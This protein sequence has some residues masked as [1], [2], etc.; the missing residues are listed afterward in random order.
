MKKIKI[1]LLSNKKLVE[2]FS[3]LTLLQFLN[4]L[5]PL[6]SYPYLV[7]T[8]GTSIYGKI[9]FAT[10]ILNYFTIFVSFGFSTSATKDV[11]V[12][13]DNKEKLAEIISSV[14]I[15]RL[16]LFIITLFLVGFLLFLFEDANN[17]KLLYL[18]SLWVCLSEVLFPS[19]YFQGIEKMKYISIISFVVRLIST[20]LLF[21]YVTSKD[22]YLMVPLLNLLSVL[23]AGV[24]SFRII[25]VSHKIKLFIPDYTVIKG[26]FV[27]SMPIFL[28]NASIQIYVSTNK[29][30]IGLFLGMTEVSYYDLGEKLLNILKIPQM[31]LGQALF[32][33]VSLEKNT[34]FLKKIFKYSMILNILLFFGLAVFADQIIV[35]IAGK[36]MLLAKW[37]VII[38]GL[39][40]PIIAA[41]N[42]FGILTL[43]PFGFNKVFSKIIMFSGLIFIVQ[44]LF[45]WIFDLITIY[46]LSSITVITE[47][48]VTF[49]MYYYCKKNNLWT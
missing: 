10:A 6:V 19:F 22:D 8:L 47:L 12:N 20:A 39:T 37:V 24:I 43:I 3:Y 34:S 42:I 13:R 45:L 31:I 40:L 2:N 49:L 23:I 11:S 44:F 33:K 35:L 18:A 17:N 29:V 14:L 21:V 4:L 46:S 30:L 48:F 26:Y 27:D 15:L 25:L 9:V 38:L 16:I 28:S 5:L 32:P 1:L 41:S 36:E 7:R